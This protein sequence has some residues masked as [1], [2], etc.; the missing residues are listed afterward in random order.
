MNAFLEVSSGERKEVRDGFVIGRVQGCD[1]VISDPKASRRHARLSVAGSVVEIEDLESHN[2]TLLN[3]KPVQ[4]RVLRDGDEIRIGATVL[5][6]R[7]KG[8]GAATGAGEP[9]ELD[10][11]GL[12]GPEPAAP[13]AAPARPQPPPPPP[14]PPRASAP[15][16]PPPP[17]PPSAAGGDVLEFAD[18]V[19]AVRPAKPAQPPPASPGAVR[20]REQ[21]A[22]QGGVLQ[23]AAQRQRGIKGPLGDDLGQMS[24]GMKLVWM[25]VGLAA[26]GGL[27]YLVMRLAS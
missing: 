7:E 22:R 20:S 14:P 15:P 11:G 13:A 4:K 23:F 21:P 5:H 27:G 25:V 16:P 10:L 24:A 26:A 18:E 8:S 9:E 2:G 6:F 17:P 3:G 19:V 1:L 12:G